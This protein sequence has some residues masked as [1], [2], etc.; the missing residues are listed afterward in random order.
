M[1]RI[2]IFVASVER[3]FFELKKSNMS[4]RTNIKKNKKKK[5][6]FSFHIFNNFLTIYYF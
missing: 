1:L 4:N 2:S 3:S 5:L 6:I